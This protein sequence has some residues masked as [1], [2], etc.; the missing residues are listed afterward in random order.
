MAVFYRLAQNNN[1]KSAQYG[2]WYAK[3]VATQV[4]DTEAMAEI[5]QRNCSMKKS[6][7]L[8]VINEL[9]EVMG[10]ALRDSKRVKID[11]FGSFKL[12]LVTTPADSAEDFSVTKNIAKVRVNF[13]PE[14]KK[15]AGKIVSQAF[16]DG[17]SVTE[18]PKNAAGEGSE[19]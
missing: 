1:Q 7:V 9:A 2:K 15:S 5:I 12:G 17:V 6:D 11:G 3:A 13:R 10:D 4:M 18:L 14:V 16:I 8:A 19:E